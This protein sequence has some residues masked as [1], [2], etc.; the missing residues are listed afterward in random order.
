[1]RR[2]ILFSCVLA[3]WLAALHGQGSGQ[4]TPQ[5]AGAPPAQTQI[6]KGTG[7]IL[8]RTLDVG[9]GQPVAGALVVLTG[10]GDLPG[11]VPGGPL[12]AAPVTSAQLTASP[13]RTV[14]TNGDGYFFFRELNGGRYSLSVSA[15]G[16]LNGGYLQNKPGG[17]VHFLDLGEN[18]KR[19]DVPVRLWKYA[20]VSGTVLD[21]AGE[22][23]VGAS[24]RIL[25][26]S[27]TAGRVRL[28][29]SGSVAQT[30]D[31]G[32]YRAG[33]LTPGDYVVG[34]IVTQSTI[35]AALADAYADAVA[36]AVD[37]ARAPPM[38]GDLRNNGVYSPSGTGVRVGDLIFQMS[39]RKSV[40]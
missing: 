15:I 13:P 36:Q 21:E 2:G 31:R 19:G 30:D 28:Q 27:I 8:G 1:M 6:R 34:I 26:R 20:A 38:M 29:S 18:E 3:T 37:P 22:P 5:S 16:Y 7:F 23:A 24:V 11:G 32:V 35:P 25:Q 40:V 10:Y 12:A 9:T 4:T 33:S 14:I 39:D 17:T